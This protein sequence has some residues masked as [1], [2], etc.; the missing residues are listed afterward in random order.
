MDHASAS[1]LTRGML[2]MPL[3]NLTV[4]QSIILT[5]LL[6]IQR[7]EYVFVILPMLTTLLT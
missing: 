4:R 3:V 2:P 7:A 5:L 6:P 1:L